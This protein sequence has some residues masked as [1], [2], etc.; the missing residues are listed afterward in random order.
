M[1]EPTAVDLCSFEREVIERL[2]AQPEPISVILSDRDFR[3][4]TIV[5]SLLAAL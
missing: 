5:V 4:Q 3:S 1:N 2:K